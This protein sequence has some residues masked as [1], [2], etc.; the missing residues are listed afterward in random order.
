MSSSN[1]IFYEQSVVRMDLC[2][3]TRKK[4]SS[5]VCGLRCVRVDVQLK[6]FFFFNLNSYDI[7]TFDLFNVLSA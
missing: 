4:S 1:Y 3:V 7:I 5:S 2:T 6:E